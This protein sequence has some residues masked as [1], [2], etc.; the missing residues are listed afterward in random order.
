VPRPGE[1]SESP[2]LECGVVI[3]CTRSGKAIDYVI[4]SH[5]IIPELLEGRIDVERH[6]FDTSRVFF[7]ILTA[8]AVWA[9]FLEPI[10]GL[11]SFFVPFRFMQVAG[12]VAFGSCSASKNKRL[13]AAAIV[14]I[15][16]LLV[17][18]ITFTRFQLGQLD[19]R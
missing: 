3:R 15:V 17:T 1:S 18:G 19:I 7:G 10:M 16:L 8:T 12:I 6:Y 14:L 2:S 11:R 4:A 13:H 5:I 9:M